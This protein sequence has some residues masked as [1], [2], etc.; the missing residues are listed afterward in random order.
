M[1]V[2]QIRTPSTESESP[3]TPDARVLLQQIG[4][5]LNEHGRLRVFQHGIIA[6]EDES[7]SPSP[8]EEKGNERQ[9]QR[10]STAGSRQGSAGRQGPPRGSWPAR[11]VPRI[12]ELRATYEDQL[13]SVFEAYPSLRTFADE[14]GM[15]LLA[16]S[17]IIRGLARE[18][19]FLTA[20]P[21]RRN[22]GPRAWGFW[23]AEGRF[24]WLG[25]RHT[26]FGDGSICA[27]SPDEGAWFEGGDV[28]TLIDLYSVWALRHLYLEVLGRW[29]G[30]QYGILGADHRVD[31]FYRL[32]ENK[33]EE[34][35]CCGSEIKRYVECCKPAD[36]RMNEVEL[37]SIFL[38]H[39]P[40]GFNSRQPP[41]SI[42]DFVEGRRPAPPR[43]VDVFPQAGSG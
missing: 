31:A 10:R 16:K 34:L 29:P 22:A 39:I 8:H 32:R 11:A 21:N 27:F 28:R 42:L 24:S 41:S 30:K 20:L 2:A 26:N 23:V 33:D 15:W 14:D 38:R 7:F 13:A 3:L 25:P 37:M 12:E 17:S 1:R 6:V 40:G 4:A 43:I 35:C 36:R 18:A 5:A 19:T 9:R